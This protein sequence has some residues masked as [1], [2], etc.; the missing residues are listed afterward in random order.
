MTKLA[1]VSISEVVRTSPNAGMVDPPEA[2]RDATAAGGAT[3]LTREG[4]TSPSPPGP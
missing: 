4:P 1:T 3:L 2:I